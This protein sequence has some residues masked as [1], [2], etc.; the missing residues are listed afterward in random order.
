MPMIYPDRMEFVDGKRVC[1]YNRD[2]LC[3]VQVWCDRCGWYP[4]N[5]DLRNR[6]V[7]EVLAKREERE[8]GLVRE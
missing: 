7:R 5:D 3:P 1:Q 8:S 6:R 4:P 2:V